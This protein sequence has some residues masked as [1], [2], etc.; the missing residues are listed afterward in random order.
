M[1][2]TASQPPAGR[3]KRSTPIAGTSPLL[4]RSLMR[5]RDQNSGG[6]GGIHIYRSMTALKL[7]PERGAT[8]SF[9]PSPRGADTAVV[10]TATDRAGSPRTPGGSIVAARHTVLTA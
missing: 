9:A 5:L 10:S 7:S 3:D 1:V 2:R 8:D 4:N 6:H